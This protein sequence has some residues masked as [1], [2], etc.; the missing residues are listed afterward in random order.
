MKIPFWLWW[1][2]YFETGFRFTRYLLYLVALFGLSSDDWQTTFAL[3]VLVGIVSLVV[4]YLWI[5]LEL[6]DAE[7]EI[8]NIINPFQREVRRKLGKNH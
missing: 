1:L 8:N 3:G 7:N 6:A 5:E 2:K 4:G